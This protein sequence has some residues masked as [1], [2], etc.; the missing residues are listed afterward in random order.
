MDPRRQGAKN[1]IVLAGPRRTA[2][3]E[4]LGGALAKAAVARAPALARSGAISPASITAAAAS[5]PPT[6]ATLTPMINATG[7]LMHTDLGR[8]PLSA[9]A[10]EAVR[11]AT[12]CTDV[13]FDLATGKRG[14]FRQPGAVHLVNND[15]APLALATTSKPTTAWRAE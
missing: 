6:A 9:A 2:A 5:L 10:R 14:R 11:A 7:V 13:E 15:A 12:G 8:A 1:R 4:R 3:R